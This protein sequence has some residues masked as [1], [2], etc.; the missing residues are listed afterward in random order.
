MI[1]Q[2]ALVREALAKKIAGEIVLSSEAGK[3]ISKWRN[4][5]K[6]SQRRLADEIGVMP[7]VISDY[8]NGRRKSPGIRVVRKLV[9]SMISIDEKRGGR[10]IRE[11]SDWTGRAALSEA[12]LDIKEFNT[13]VSVRDF[14]KLVDAA[15]VAR[16]DLDETRLHGYT[17]IDSVKAITEVSPF[18]LV[19]L[20][21]LTT[22]RALIFTGTH[23]GRSS[24]VAIKVSGLRP[25]LV[26]LHGAESIDELAKRI[27]DVESIPLAITRLK[28]ID[29][30]LAALK[31]G[32]GS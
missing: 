18:D 17:V 23:R 22:E 6:L 26:V 12:V 32:F 10:I 11:F 15:I 19:K 14:C 4:I 5:F 13:A 8:E 7:S 29:T 31:K 30:L 16:D 21:G 3:A 27:A 9:E 25:G 24:M 1:D 20:Y 28:S 2:A